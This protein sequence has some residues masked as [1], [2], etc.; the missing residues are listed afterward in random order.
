MS[1]LH[2]VMA[3]SGK[4]SKKGHAQ[5]QGCGGSACELCA[6]RVVCKSSFDNRGL[7]HDSIEHDLAL[8]NA[9][10]YPS[11][12]SSLVMC[13]WMSCRR[14]P[15]CKEEINSVLPLV[16]VERVRCGSLQSFRT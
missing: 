15:C 11:K 2:E 6:H 7:R 4:M 3:W 12:G 1:T 10:W 16:A 5:P 9:R 8:V 13:V 14:R